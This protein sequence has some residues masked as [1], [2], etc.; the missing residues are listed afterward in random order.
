MITLDQ[1]SEILQQIRPS[2]MTERI[3]FMQSLSRVLAEDLR[4]DSDVPPFDRSAMDGYACRKEDIG[5]VLNVVG[6]IPAGAVVS[7][8]VSR[9][10]CMRIMTGGLIPEGADHVIKKEDIEEIGDSLIR[11]TSPAGK[12]NIR[13]KGEDIIQGDVVLKSGCLLNPQHIALLAS[14]GFMQPLVFSKPTVAIISTGNELVTPDIFPGPAQIRESNGYQ[15]ASQAAQMGLEPEYLGIARDDKKQIASLLE[16]AL[17]SYKITLITGGVSVG[18]YDYIPGV[19]QELGVTI[20]FHR[21]RVKPGKHLIFGVKDGNYVFG[22]PGNP[23][24]SF[25]MFEVMAKPFLMRC[26]G[27]EAESGGLFLPLAE[28]FNRKSPELVEFLPVLIDREGYV[29]TVTYHGSAH[30]H[31]YAGAEGLME[32]PSGITTVKKREKVLVRLL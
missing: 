26:M 20:H 15:L 2:L 25:V 12:S 5:N 23:V 3:P 29:K 28:D 21:I 27:F 6:E 17:G 18:D 14:G 1:A 10:E 8:R 22:F 4:S 32:I 13:R 11:C 16:N 30:V 9:N 7:H 19:L 24:S 31:A